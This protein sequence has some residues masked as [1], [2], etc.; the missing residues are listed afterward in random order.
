MEDQG[1][2]H[3]ATC[4][5]L[6]IRITCGLPNPRGYLAILFMY[7]SVFCQS[8]FHI[9]TLY[10]G[11]HLVILS[12]IAKFSWLTLSNSR[13]RFSLFKLIMICTN[14]RNNLV[15]NMKAN[16]WEIIVP[17][18]RY[19]YHTHA[20]VSHYLCLYFHSLL[21]CRIFQGFMDLKNGSTSVEPF[22]IAGGS[23]LW[24]L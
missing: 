6:K 21:L 8:S 13:C 10:W 3:L 22:E 18:K 14:A 23:F 5:H 12:R 19:N 11:L 2:Y 4:T 17:T 15:N 16:K 20:T 9:W 24:L 7:F 1:I